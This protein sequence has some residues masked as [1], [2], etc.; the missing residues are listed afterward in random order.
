MNIA[1]I[2]AG[3]IACQLAPTL[4]L[5]HNLII[6]DGDVYEPDNST[7]QFP[8]L[9]STSNKAKTLAEMINC[10]GS[11]RNSIAYYDSYLEQLS[12]YDNMED[13]VPNNRIDLIIGAVD[14]MLS[15]EIICDIANTT[16]TPAILGGN[17]EFMGEAHLYLH[18]MY[19]PFDHFNFNDDSPAPFSCNSDKM[20]EKHPQTIHSNG[21][22]VGCIHHLINSLHTVKDPLNAIAW[23]QMELHSSASKRVRDFI[24]SQQ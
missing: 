4:Y 14:N 13:V 21:L 16:K 1:I 17:E 5:N 11:T 22:A 6:A 18:D 12:D 3:G 15:R 8:A 7:R 9:K 2:G 23:S 24:D 10:F 19:S 20:L